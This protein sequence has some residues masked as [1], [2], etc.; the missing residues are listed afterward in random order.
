MTWETIE[1]RTCLLEAVPYPAVAAILAKLPPAAQANAGRPGSQ[2][3]A[4]AGL[5]LPP[6]RE[7]RTA[8]SGPGAAPGHVEA[9]SGES[10]T[11]LAQSSGSAPALV[12]DY[13]LLT[14][15]TSVTLRSDLTYYVNGSVNV[16]SATPFQTAQAGA[17][18]L[19]PG[20]PFLNRGTPSID[21]TLLAQ[22]PALTTFAPAT[23]TAAIAG[24]RL[25]GRRAQRDADGLPDLGYHYDPLDLLVSG[26]LVSNG[27]LTLTNRMAVG[28]YGTAGF[29]L[30]AAGRLVCGGDPLVRNRIVRAV[31]VQ[32]QPPLGWV[33]GVNDTLLT[34]DST[35]TSASEIRMRFTETVVPGGRG[36]HFGGTGRLGR[37]A[38]TDC[39]LTGGELDFSVDCSQAVLG[40]NSKAV[41][42]AYAKNAKVVLPSLASFE[43]K[44]RQAE[45]LPFPAPG[46]LPEPAAPVAQR[47]G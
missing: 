3:T 10:L 20:G 21:A 39:Q 13:L 29:K 17:H 45:I 25:I 30:G 26:V 4:K 14:S 40:H 8:Q 5:T 9:A 18:Y 41:H 16:Q 22:L 11:R 33:A 46:T 36:R 32:E 35:A 19:G 34:D 7:A 24:D 1:G 47:G 43:K 37:L 28:V 6:R 31:T 2:R 23:Q 12:I 15:Q 27:T 38:L 44:A 42:R